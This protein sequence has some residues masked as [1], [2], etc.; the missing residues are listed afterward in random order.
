[1]VLGIVG[2][3]LSCVYGI[4]VVLAI[5]ALCLAPSA[6]RDVQAKGYAS[7]DGMIKAGAI[8]SWI[9]VVIGIVFALIFALAVVM[10]ARDG[11][12]S[13]MGPADR[14]VVTTVTV[15]SGQ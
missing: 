4:G 9:S 14:V 1:M 10:S 6:R 12:N 13:S 7:G 5:V 3:C 15:P 11:Y 2:L 8:C